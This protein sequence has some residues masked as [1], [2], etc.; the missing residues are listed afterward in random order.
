M[1]GGQTSPGNAHPPSRLCPPHIRPCFPYK[2][3][4]LKIMDSLPGMAASYAIPVRQASVLPAASFR[5]HLAVDTLAV[6]LTVP[7]VGPVEDFHLQVGAPCRA[8]H[9]RRAPGRSSP[10]LLCFAPSQ[11]PALDHNHSSPL[12][13]GLCR[14]TGNSPAPVSNRS[15]GNSN[16]TRRANHRQNRHAPYFLAGGKSRHRTTTTAAP[17]CRGFAAGREI[18]LRPF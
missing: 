15:R 7:L 4:A 9:K 10:G 11:I 17:W 1:A 14:R 3:R 12:V 13:P 5:S 6:R 8:H 18:L 2:Y 16:H